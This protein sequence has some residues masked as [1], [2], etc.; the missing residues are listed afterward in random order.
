MFSLEVV[1]T[2]RPSSTPPPFYNLIFGY[3]NRNL[4]D[5]IGKPETLNRNKNLR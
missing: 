1:F 3:C 4:L 5:E 2:S